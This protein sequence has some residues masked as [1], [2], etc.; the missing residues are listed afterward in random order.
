MRQSYIKFYNLNRY[1]RVWETAIRTPYQNKGGAE[2][3]QGG[4]ND[5]KSTPDDL[6]G[7]C[8]CSSL[9]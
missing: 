5:E 6:Q 8:P 4:Q 2:A 3:K 1:N 9:A 7:N